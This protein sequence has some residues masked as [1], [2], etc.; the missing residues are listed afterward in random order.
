MWLCQFP[1]NLFTMCIPYNI[2]LIPQRHEMNSIFF[3]NTRES[4]SFFKPRSSL[5]ICQKNALLTGLHPQS[6]G[7]NNLI[8]SSVSPLDGKEVICS[9]GFRVAVRLLCAQ[10]QVWIKFHSVVLFGCIASKCKVIPQAPFSGSLVILMNEEMA[11][12]QLCFYMKVL[13]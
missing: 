8:S 6:K 4:K 7:F 3:K 1:S 10:G 13:P 2:I 12:E 5:C 9:R 11:E